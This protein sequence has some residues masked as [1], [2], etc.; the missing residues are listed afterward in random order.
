M[1]VFGGLGHHYTA[2]SDS[3]RIQYNKISFSAQILYVF[4]LGCAK[5]SILLMLHRVFSLA[6]NAFRIVA[7]VVTALSICWML[8]AIL[9]AI[10][11]C[12]PLQKLWDTTL[13]GECG[14]AVSRGAP[15]HFFRTCICWFLQ[16]VLC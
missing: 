14:N 16:E 10:F 15:D 9:V 8:M 4:T 13:P 6:S 1:V 11:L 5:L 3:E 2:L 12:R 7:H